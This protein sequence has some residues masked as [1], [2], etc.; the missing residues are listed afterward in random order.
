MKSNGK[1]KKN[2]REL[3]QFELESFRRDA[4]SSAPT[5]GDEIITTKIGSN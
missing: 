2:Q 1:K 5:H 4:L 3:M